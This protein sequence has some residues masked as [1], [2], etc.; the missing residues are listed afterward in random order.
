MGEISLADKGVLF[1]DEFVEFKKDVLESLREPLEEKKVSVTR[2]MYK[3]EFPA[4]FIFLA[5]C[6]PCKC[7]NAWK[8]EIYVLVRREKYQDI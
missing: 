8:T 3:A 7:G 4:D 2:A 5:A 6:N 1:L